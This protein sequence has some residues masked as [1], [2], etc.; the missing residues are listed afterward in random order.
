MLLEF[1]LVLIA[2]VIG[3][4][5]TA[6]VYSRLV[7]NVDIR[8]LG[9]GNMGARNLKRQFGFAAG[10]LVALA[11]IFKG[12]LAVWLTMLAGLAVE[13]QLL[14]GAAAILG[15]DYPLFAAFR[16]GQGFAATTGVFLALFPLFTLI[17]IAVYIFLFLVFHNSDIAAG[18]GM[19]LLVLLEALQRPPLIVMAFMVLVLLFVPVKQWLD[20][21]RRE[22]LRLTREERPVEKKSTLK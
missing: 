7:H 14:A 3:S 18:V 13:W 8:T 16:G 1:T 22:E 15:H 4:F 10:L 17:G 9:D 5:P 20:R 12:A 21:P 6:L 2:Y 19:A 11:D